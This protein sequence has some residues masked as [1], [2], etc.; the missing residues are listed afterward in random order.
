MPPC[1]CGCTL[2][3]CIQDCPPP[4]TATHTQR[5][6]KTDSSS[7]YLSP[8]FNL[9]TSFARTSITTTGFTLEGVTGISGVVIGYDISVGGA[10]ITNSQKHDGQDGSYY[11]TFD[12]TAPVTLEVH[13]I[14]IHIITGVTWTTTIS[15]GGSETT[16]VK[17]ARPCAEE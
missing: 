15:V 12:W 9:D 6:T 17:D 13:L 16:E 8:T 1:E 5:F 3:P 2:S 10:T 14:D 7:S 11:W 4:P